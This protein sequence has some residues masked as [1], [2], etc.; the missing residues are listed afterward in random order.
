MSRERYQARSKKVQRLGRDGLVEL[1]RA[2]GEET[3]VSQ[4]TA[5]ISFGPERPAR[6]DAGQDGA[7]SRQRRQ[8]REQA[9]QSDPVNG[10]DVPTPERPATPRGAADVPMNAAAPSEKRERYKRAAVRRQH[11]PPPRLIYE[12][13]K[14]G[15]PQVEPRQDMTIADTPEETES[16]SPRDMEAVRPRNTGTKPAPRYLPG[17][18]RQRM[19]KRRKEDDGHLQFNHERQDAPTPD[20]RT[21][22]K[23]RQTADRT[24]DAAEPEHTRLRFEDTPK[25]ADLPANAPVTR[26]QKRYAA[27]DPDAPTTDTRTA[28]EHRQAT[29]RPP[30]TAKPERSRLRFEDAPKRADSPADAP[31][32]RQQKRYEAA[33]RPTARSGQGSKHTQG[34][35]P[36][37]RH[38]Q[39]ERPSVRKPETPRRRLRFESE[40]TPAVKRTG[41]AL[42]RTTTTAAAATA[43]SKLQDAE[44]NNVAVEAAHRGEFVAERGAGRFLRWNRS[45]RQAA[46]SARNT[47]TI[48]QTAQGNPK[49]SSNPYSRWQQKQAIKRE[50]AAAKHT[51]TKTVTTVNRTVAKTAEKAK[52]KSADFVRKHKK[53]FLV[54]GGL[55]LVVVMFSS[56]MTSCSTLFQGG[57]SAAVAATTY[58]SED[59]DML[60]AETWYTA[61]ENELQTYLNTYQATHAYD[62]YHFILDEIEHDPYVLI[63]ALTALRGGAWKFDEVQ[64]T[65]Q[66]L[67]DRQYILTESVTTETRTRTVDGEEVEYNYYIC[68]VTLV[69]FDLSH[70]PVYIMS[71]SQ[72]SMYAMY[73][74]AL[75]NRTDLFPTSSYINRY[76]VVGYTEHEIPASALE[77]ETFASMISEAEKY[78]GYPYVWGGYNPNTS[79]DC[80]GFVSWVINQS[81][82]NVGR[83]DA[84]SLYNICTTTSSPQPGDL[85]FFTGT[86]DAG[87]PVTHVGLYV[88]DGWMI[89]AGDPISYC[90]IGDS[91]YQSHFYAYGVLP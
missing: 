25:R 12:Q 11:D 56:L 76:A 17:K 29:D 21:A 63:S 26:Q 43:H 85:V 59:I 44:G 36:T 27:A 18:A 1:D 15:E 45:R 40:K 39:P 7:R 72:L 70:V 89:H 49:F 35:Q 60:A 23:H 51:G 80:S 79:F 20:K 69:N 34:A 24:P 68:T 5:D 3:R 16:A 53:G 81:G 75:G 31:A 67:F 54:I 14:G 61:K 77:D 73:M 46:S 6:Q 91:Y 55:A 42:A 78:L 88:G 47:Q 66:M 38:T 71:E 83:L 65:L 30:D 58:P 19:E 37:E 50:Y 13:D 57:A 52:Q 90:Y 48:R 33:A 87:V 41:G 9:A 74:G 2:T 22:A 32:T 4:R 84:Q 62:E 10:P 8:I 86:Y 82:W 64:D 28:T